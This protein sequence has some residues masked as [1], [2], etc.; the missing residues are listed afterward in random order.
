MGV[1][2]TWGDKYKDSK[3]IVLSASPFP[4]NVLKR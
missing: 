3:K 4:S 2:L 1:E